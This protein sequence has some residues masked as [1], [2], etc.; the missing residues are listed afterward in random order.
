MFYVLTTL[1]CWF[2][3][4]LITALMYY[5]ISLAVL[6]YRIG[7]CVKQRLITFTRVPPRSS[8]NTFLAQSLDNDRKVGFGRV[9][10]PE[11]TWMRMTQRHNTVVVAT[12]RKSRKLYFSGTSRACSRKKRKLE[13][14]KSKGSGRPIRTALFKILLRAVTFTWNSLYSYFS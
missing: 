9:R 5:L 8:S 1:A 11:G 14:K 13:M 10:S 7:V 4:T 6:A 3:V 2:A 12:K